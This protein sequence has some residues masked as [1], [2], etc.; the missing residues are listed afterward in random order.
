LELVKRLIADTKAT[1]L[2][3]FLGREFDQ[4]SKALAGVVGA[5]PCSVLPIKAVQSHMPV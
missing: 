3:T 1:T 5:L 4:V 2:G